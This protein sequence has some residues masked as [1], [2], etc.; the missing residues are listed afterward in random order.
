MSTVTGEDLFQ[1]LIASAGNPEIDVHENDFVD[2]QFE[3]LGYDS[4]AL[5]E[6]AAR[7]EQRY[8]VALPEEK[9]IEMT[10]PRQLLEFVN[11]AIA[12]N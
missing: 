3:D 5:I 6:A 8:N 11:A 9:L 2:Y 12:D 4:L 7:V 10:T 1:I